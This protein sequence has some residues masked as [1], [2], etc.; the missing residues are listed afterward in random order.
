MKI[1]QF[2][3]ASKDEKQK[4]AAERVARQLKRNQEKLIDDLDA[5]KDKLL[6]KKDALESINADISDAKLESWASEYQQAT[7]DIALI[8]KEIEI[9]NKT[10]KDLFDDAKKAK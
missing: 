3:T 1:L 5:K 8:E 2:L 9:A 6:A 7:V 10:L 4:K